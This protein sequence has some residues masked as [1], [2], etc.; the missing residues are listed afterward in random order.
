MAV[1][2]VFLVLAAQYESLALPLAII[3]IVPMCLF[4]AMLGVNLRGMDN[5]ILTQIGLIVLIALAAKNAILVVEFARAAEDE[6]GMSPVEAA[7]HAAR[8][9]LRPI[10]MTSLAF[11]LGTVPLV[12]ASGAGAELRQALGT[13]VFYGMTGVTGFGL[14]FTPTFYVLCRRMADALHRRARR[15]VLM[16]AQ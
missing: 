1:L 11:I 10:L 4:A 8:T 12:M 6:L 9:R 7:I 2:F 3:L 16:P 13:A 5:N 14:L 15:P